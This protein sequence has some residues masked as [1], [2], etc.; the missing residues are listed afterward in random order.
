MERDELM[1]RTVL[2]VDDQREILQLLERMLNNEPYNSLFA[3]SAFE[4]LKILEERTVDVLVT[5]IIMPEIGG[6]EL[7]MRVKEKYPQIVRVILSGYAQIPSIL[8]AIN[9]GDIYRFITKPWKVTDE[10]KKIIRDALDYS[11]FQKHKSCREDSGV[12]SFDI[13]ELRKLL[14]SCGLPY[15][16]LSESSEVI[17]SSSDLEGEAL[18]QFLSE[19]HRSIISVNGESRLL[20]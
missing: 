12:T 10:A 20:F 13:N 19:N 11:E 15:V 8:S 17:L 2:F 6:L 7:I 1:E 4:A 3:T 18:G 16:L 9:T 14:D 5:D